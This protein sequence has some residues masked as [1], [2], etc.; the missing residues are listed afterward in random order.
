[1]LNIGD[2]LELHV[3]K[4]PFPTMARFTFLLASL[5]Q[6]VSRGDALNIF[7]THYTGTVNTLTFNPTTNALT[8]NSSVTIGGQPSWMHWDSATRMI[9]TS[10][11]TSF[12]SASV[13]AVSAAANGGLVS[14]GKA[15]APLG[16]VACS[17]YGNGGYVSIAH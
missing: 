13:N 2:L 8:T 6:Y 5:L 7:V 15:S 4:V 14:A 3:A 1:V 10:D 9:Y 17:L 12:G 11:E 16:G